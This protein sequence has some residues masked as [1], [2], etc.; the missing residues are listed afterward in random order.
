[1]SFIDCLMFS[2][3]KI[4][5]LLLIVIL[6]CC[7]YYRKDI[8]FRF[9]Y[10]QLKKIECRTN[11]S[12]NLPCF[13]NKL[14]VHRVNS[15]QRFHL[16]KDYFQGIETDV[17]Y[18]SSIHNFRIWHPPENRPFDLYMESLL[19][20]VKASNKKIWLDMRGVDSS[21][22]QPAINIFEKKIQEY[23]LK[24]NV[25]TELY[26]VTAAN[27]FAQHGFAVS[28]NVPPAILNKHNDEI[29]GW[30]QQISSQ[31]KFV[32]QSVEYVDSLKNKFPGKKI[33]TWSLAFNNY[34]H[35][36]KLKKLADDTSICIVLINV[37]SRYHY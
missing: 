15:L 7:F 30:K 20:E 14:W 34:F 17:Y 24:Q 13:T 6:F 27:C 35:I 8:L 19:K 1:M 16:V 25:L 3:R 29:T 2:L 21:N 10:H 23:Q 32:S 9:Q 26:D 18:D 12:L 31:V 28:L 22:A 33:I 5:I 36:E 11:N 4:F 37:K